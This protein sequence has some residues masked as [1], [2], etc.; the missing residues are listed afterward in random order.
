MIRLIDFKTIYNVIPFGKPLNQV[1]ICVECDDEGLKELEKYFYLGVKSPSRSMYVQVKEHAESAIKGFING[2]Y[3]A[4]L[5]IV[6]KILFSGVCTTV[7]W[8]DGTKTI[9]RCKSDTEFSAYHAFT[10]ALA[11]KIYGSNSQVNKII[12]RNIQLETVADEYPKVIGFLS[13]KGDL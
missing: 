10:A 11:K 4:P 6:K 2:I 13:D 5:P 3:G 9:V 7:F 12:K 1:T 8:L